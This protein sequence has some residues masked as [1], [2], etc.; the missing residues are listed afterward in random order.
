MPSEI[1]IAFL[2]LSHSQESFFE[3]ANN[4]S[5]R[6]SRKRKL[7]WNA[8]KEGFITA[9]AFSEKQLEVQMGKTQ[10]I[11]RGVSLHVLSPLKH[12]ARC[13]ARDMPIIFY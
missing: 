2:S 1:L 12:T 11:S 7:E 13:G 8:Q 5:L 9:K 4:W 6:K 3:N 10:A